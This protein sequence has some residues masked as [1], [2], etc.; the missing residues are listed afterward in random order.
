MEYH[1]KR[2][3]IDKKRYKNEYFVALNMY[4]LIIIHLLFTGIKIIIGLMVVL[5]N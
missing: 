2:K 1:I 3:M 4:K 5:S